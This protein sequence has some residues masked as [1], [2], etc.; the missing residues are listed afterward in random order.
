M[1]SEASKNLALKERKRAIKESRRVRY[2]ENKSKT[3]ES[4]NK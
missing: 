3:I 4:E 1:L 2:I